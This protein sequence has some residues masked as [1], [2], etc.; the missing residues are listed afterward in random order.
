MRSTTPYPKVNF[1]FL[2]FYSFKLPLN[3][4]LFFLLLQVVVPYSSLPISASPMFQSYDDLRLSKKPLALLS[5]RDPTEE[6][7]SNPSFAEQERDCF[8]FL[9]SFGA[10]AMTSRLFF[11]QPG[12]VS[13]AWSYSASLRSVHYGVVKPSCLP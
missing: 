3:S 2:L 8:G 9:T 7:R 12:D 1:V 10:L 5:L 6:G 4:L 11:G 13:R